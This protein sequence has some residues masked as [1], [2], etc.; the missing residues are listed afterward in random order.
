MK[1]QASWWRVP[2]PGGPE[3][4]KA[5]Y[6]TRTFARHAHDRFAI[7]VIE[8]GGL[9]FRYR[10]EEVLAPA[11]WVNLAFPG[12]AHCGRP[13][14]SEGWTYRMFYLDPAQVAVVARDLDPRAREMPF[15]P[16]GAVWD[17]VLAKRIASLHRYCEQPGSDPL[18]RQTRLGLVLQDVLRRH[19]VSR[20]EQALGQRRREVETA[21]RYLDEHSGERV[22][23]DELADLTGMNPYGLVRCFT[24]EL[25]MPPHVYLVQARVRRAA[26]ML[27][28]GIPPVQAAQD[29]GFADQS[30][31]NRHFLR[32]F[33]ISPG[34]FQKAFRS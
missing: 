17:P 14:G 27:R 5:S 26:A 24:L 3:L 28:R 21:R 12:E 34:M 16:A 32:C 33:G 25:G 18:E 4:L 1:E 7:G 22:L 11:G 2:D 29:A 13:A 8:A 19:S 31:L 6:R 30:H 10:G 20:A 9:A 23:L 15:I